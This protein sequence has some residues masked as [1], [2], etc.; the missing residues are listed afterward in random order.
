MLCEI[1]NERPASVIFTQETMQGSSERHMCER[2]AF[3]SKMFHFD[4]NQ[5]PLSIQQFLS[6]WLGSSEPFQSQQQAK[7]PLAEGPECP[8]C[9]L[10][11]RKFLDIGKFGCS[12]CYDT[13]RERLPRLFGKLHNGHSSH[14]GKI[15]VSFN[16]LFAVKKRIEEIRLKMQEAIE[17][18]RFEE[19]ASLRD[20]A[21]ELKRLMMDGGGDAHVN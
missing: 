19:A 18:E 16:E 15:P 12:T 5:E 13:F 17:E 4:P 3:Q 14:T 9:G 21:N 2:C 20:E 7:E 1:C 10:T 6:N 11:F 8:D